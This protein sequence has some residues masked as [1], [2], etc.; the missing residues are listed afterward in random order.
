M[1]NVG[2]IGVTYEATA[3]FYRKLCDRSQEI[4]GH[5]HNPDILIH[6]RDFDDYLESVDRRTEAWPRLMLAS[7]R[8][9][10]A[11]GCDF[12][13]CPANSNHVVY[14]EVSAAAEL[15][16]RPAWKSTKEMIAPCSF[17]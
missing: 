2:V 10:A 9:L 12:V 8:R 1:K 14:E 17:G 3:F 16:W 15:P 4:L 6:T 11:A 7:I 5:G 13:V